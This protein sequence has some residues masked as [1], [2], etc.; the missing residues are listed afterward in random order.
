MFYP[1]THHGNSSEED[2]KPETF[3]KKNSLMFY[4]ELPII[5]LETLKYMLTDLLNEK[6][7][8]KDEWNALI[9]ALDNFC[10]NVQKA[11]DQ[12]LM[13]EYQLKFTKNK[14]SLPLFV[15]YS[16]NDHKFRIKAELKSLSF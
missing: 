7:L 5:N 8:S 4:T 16:V 14:D 6:K 13:S 3:H 11:L 1:K 10:S 9:S 2:F 12:L 15:Y